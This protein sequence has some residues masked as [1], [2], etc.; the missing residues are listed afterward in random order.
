MAIP[1][2]AIGLRSAFLA[3][4]CVMIATLV[5]TISIDG[6]PFR[7][8]LL[9]PWMT[10]T[11][12]DFYINVVPFAAWTYYK[13]SN[14][15]TAVIWIILLICF[16]SVTT[17]AYIFIQFLK[18]S[19]QESLQDPMYYVLLQH[20]TKDG[21]GQKQKNHSSV[22]PARIG[23]SIL[24]CLMAATLVYTILTDGSPFR[25]E[26]FT[27]WMVATLIDFYIN[28]AAL[29]VWIA[30]KE[31]SWLHGFLWIILLICFGSISTCAYIVNQLL[32]L[33]SQDPLYLVLLKRDNSGRAL[34]ISGRSQV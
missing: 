29:S 13:E 7:R 24:G 17:C 30:Y 4:C 28:I 26:L 19:P 3:L 25:K 15:F 32:Q 22:V 23:F 11:L 6:L 12:V 27:P 20:D 8:D 34:W 33:T 21:V 2:L 14:H 9:T 5:Y 18:L 1:I 31:S 16:G 10:V